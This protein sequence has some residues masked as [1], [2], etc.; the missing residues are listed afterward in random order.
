[1]NF[2]S[3]VESIGPTILKILLNPPI[4]ILV[5]YF[6]LDYFIEMFSYKLFWITDLIIL[7]ELHLVWTTEIKALILP[8]FGGYV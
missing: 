5:L 8:S 2:K 1:M 7:F 3:S 4:L 6:I